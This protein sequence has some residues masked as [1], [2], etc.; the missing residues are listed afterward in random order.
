MAVMKAAGLDKYA[1]LA[2]GADMSKDKTDGY[3][4]G[5]HYRNNSRGTVVTVDMVLDQARDYN[6]RCY[7]RNDTTGIPRITAIPPGNRYAGN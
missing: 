7:E 2:V 5:N 4:E 1:Y 6:C 3:E